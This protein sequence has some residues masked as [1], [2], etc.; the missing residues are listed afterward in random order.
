M[1]FTKFNTAAFILD[2]IHKRFRV[3]QNAKDRV[4]RQENKSQ[5]KKTIINTIAQVIASIAGE[6]L[7]DQ[8]CDT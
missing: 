3:N 4:Q 7:T 5:E 2:N 1:N 8:N 6:I